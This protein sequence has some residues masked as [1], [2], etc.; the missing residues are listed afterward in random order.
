MLLSVSSRNVIRVAWC[1]ATTGTARTKARNYRYMN[2]KLL[3]QHYQRSFSNSAN[4]KDIPTT[5]Q[6][7]ECHCTRSHKKWEVKFQAFRAFVEKHNGRT[8]VEHSDTEAGDLYQWV[9]TQR[10]NYQQRLRGKVTPMT[11]DRI[12]ALNSLGMVWNAIQF[13]WET[14]YENLK[15]FLEEN[16]HFNVKKADNPQLYYWIANQR[17][18]KHT[19][20]TQERIQ[21]LDEIGF[22][23][24]EQID[25]MWT[26][27]YRELEEYIRIFGHTVVPFKDPTYT[28][29][30]IW[31]NRQRQNY[32]LL[33]RGRS[34]PMTKDRIELLERIDFVW[35]VHQA[36]WDKNCK[37]LKDFVEANNGAWPKQ[38]STRNSLLHWFQKQRAMAFKKKEG[39]KSHID[40]ST[41]G[42]ACRSST[43]S[44]QF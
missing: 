5:L 14:N 35:N 33:K 26:K 44:N 31:V 27:K 7:E 20:M 39:K 25:E 15:Q 2:I 21:K 9:V 36:I 34:S 13:E 10:W 41:R 30:S 8:K 38:K 40:R 22:T 6:N 3:S 23:W 1:K 12:Q 29:L 18:M 4:I 11:D 16:G 42:K 19:G 17:S 28:E 32:S 43:T 24:G 37:D